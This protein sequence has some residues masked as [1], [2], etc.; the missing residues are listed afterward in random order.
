MFPMLWWTR[1]INNIRLEYVA[2]SIWMKIMG[3][4]QEIAGKRVDEK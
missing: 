3:S 1:C 4:T 2:F